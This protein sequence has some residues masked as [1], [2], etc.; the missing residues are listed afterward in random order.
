MTIPKIG[1]IVYSSYSPAKRGVVVGID[2]PA[3]QVIMCIRTKPRDPSFGVGS[4]AVVRCTLAKGHDGDCTDGLESWPRVEGDKPGT[5]QPRLIY[6]VKRANGREFRSS[7]VTL[8]TDLIA[9]HERKLATHKAG[10]AA[11][12]A[13]REK[14]GVTTC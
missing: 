2:H 12:E 5:I 9:D 3:P 11:L 10:L 1:D 4:L 7:T 6:Q 8:L 14:L 13:Y